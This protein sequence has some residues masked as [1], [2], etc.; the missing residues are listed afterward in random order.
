MEV[1]CYVDADH[2]SDRDTYRSTTGY[3][4]TVG[5]TAVS[6]RSHLQSIVA[7]SA[8]ESEYVAITEAAM[9]LKWVREF[10]E[11]LFEA[12][13]DI[14]TLWSDIESA[15]KLVKHDK[16]RARTRHIGKR[17]HFVRLCMPGRSL[18]L[19]SSKA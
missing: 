7:L 11:N 19:R 2:A 8:T 5:R 3:V 1:A 6:W 12:Y 16:Y 13:D 10:M 9:E 15:I 17:F 4:L 18:S 14:G